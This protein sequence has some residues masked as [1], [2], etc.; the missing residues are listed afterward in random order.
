MAKTS[1][2]GININDDTTNDTLIEKYAEV[3]DMVQKSAISQQLKNTNLSGDPTS[4]SVIVRRMKTSVS[5]TLG[6]A[7]T[8]GAG[9]VLNNNP[10]TVNI[11]VDKEIVEEVA[12]KDIDL[13]GIADLLGKRMANHQLA[14]IRELD[15]AFFTEAVSGGTDKS[16]ELTELDSTV[17][18]LE[19]LIQTVE[20]VSNSNVDGV[21]R[22][23][24]AVALKPAIYG[25]L[26]NEIDLLPNPLAGGV[27]VKY[28]HDVRVFSNSR[29]SKDAIAMAVGSIAQPVKSQPYTAEKI[30]LSN[31]YAVE[32]FYSFG[33]KAVM[34]D[35][36][37]Y[38]DFDE[39]S[40]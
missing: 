6:T 26:R 9:D 10:V 24:I 12:Q 38:A 35:L 8:N 13:F 31:D 2:I 27:D 3:V 16:S 30:N 34:P 18:K 20:T 32:L 33:T 37:M 28:F 11:N 4:G 23:M 7:R 39:V 14:M 17:E 40:A 21:D 29:Q 22:S 5:Q 19:A 15:T 36:I 1:T 25:A